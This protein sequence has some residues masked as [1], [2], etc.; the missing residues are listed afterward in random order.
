LFAALGLHA[1]RAG[2]Q[3]AP[4]PAPPPAAPTAPGADLARALPEGTEAPVRVVEPEHGGLTA[5]EVAR[6]SLASSHTIRARRAELEATEAKIRQ[7][8]IE[9]FPRIT[10]RAQY[11]RLSPVDASLRGAIVGTAN[12]GAVTVGPCDP[13]QPAGPTC[14]LDSRGLPAAAA[15][16]NFRSF[17]NFY[18]LTA[19][20]TVPL[21]DY[22]LR[23]PDAAAATKAARSGASLN[24]RAEQR[25]IQNDARL[26]YYGWVGA[27]GQVTVAKKSL[28]RTRARQ[29]DAEA[30]YSLGA[31]SKADLMRLQALVANTELAV[32]E[33]ET[34]RDLRAHQ[35]GILMGEPDRSPREVGED[36]LAPAAGGLQGSLPALTSEAL[37]QRIELTALTQNS[38][39][40]RSSAGAVQARGYPRLEALGDVTYANPN[41]RIFP[42]EEKF[43]LTW[44]AGVAATWTINDAFGMS[45]SAAELEAN[46]RVLEA[47]RAALADAIR[48]EVAAAYLDREKA[49]VAIET[50]GRAA[51]AAA[52]AYRVATDLY[53]VGRAT[54]TELIEAESDLLNARLSEL[55]AH[56][57]LRA[58]EQRLRYAVGRD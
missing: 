36:V 9:Y 37:R 41:P 22:F 23:L 51:S 24:V 7:T 15:P 31:I 1:L 10:L 16:F 28:E 40:L 57:N 45:A 20:L 6:R 29:K 17:E 13:T 30:S 25:K 34:L 26:V 55:S 3:P 5:A 58:A 33:A 49:L 50:S 42:Q 35:L 46:A 48:Q 39:A 43:N 4:A 44:S 21:S 2:A 11:T 47:Q 18:A 19:S 32:K 8:T 12:P 53:R 14:V 27:V 38:R 52:E 54:T 56:V